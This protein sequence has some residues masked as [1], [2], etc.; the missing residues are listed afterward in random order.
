MKRRLLTLTVAIAAAAAPA[1]PAAG[2]GGP[3]A[4]GIDLL[5]SGVLAPNGNT[6]YVAIPDG[7]STMLVQTLVRSGVVLRSLTL[8]GLFGLPYVTNDGGVGGLSFDGKVLVLASYSLTGQPARSSRFAVVDIK[9][10]RFDRTIRLPGAFGV[11]ALSPKGRE[12]YLIEHLSQRDATRYLVRAYDLAYRRL[13]PGVIADRREP[14]ARMVGMPVTRATGPGGIWAYT[15]YARPDGTAFVH[16][17]NTAHRS[18]LCVDLPWQ[19]TS[20]WIYDV[21]LWVSRDGTELHLLQRG[22]GGRRAV[23]DTRRWTSQV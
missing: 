10:W 18:A 21:R 2:D 3:A 9:R 1:L 13:L 20:A 7:K 15:L 16:A 23:F 6:R 17:L 8:P 12:L 11:D 14:D 22:T 4:Q 19:D 5:S